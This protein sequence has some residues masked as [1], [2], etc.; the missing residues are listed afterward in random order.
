L[1]ISNALGQEVAIL[2][3]NIFKKAGSY[4]VVFDGSNLPSGIYFYKL[5]CSVFSKTGKMTLLR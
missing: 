3:D 5:Y 4:E 1:K 2:V